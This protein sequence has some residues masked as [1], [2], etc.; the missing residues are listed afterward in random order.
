MPYNRTLWVNDQEPFINDVNLNKIEQGIFDA[1][2]LAE[3]NEAAIVALSQNAVN[4]VTV[5]TAD[6][7]ATQIDS[8]VAA[9]Y[10]S[11]DYF[12]TCSSDRGFFAT[13]FMVIHDDDTVNGAAYGAIG[14]LP[15]TFETELVNGNVVINLTPTQAI[16]EVKVV[17]TLISNSGVHEITQY[18]LPIDLQNETHPVIDLMVGGGEIDLHTDLQASTGLGTG[19]EYNPDPVI[20]F[21]GID[22]TPVDLNLLS[23]TYDINTATGGL[24]LQ[25]GINTLMGA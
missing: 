9:D 15:G 2:A 18:I 25:T 24:D 4:E 19:E 21:E 7:V 16:T 1:R 17:R 3:Q 10:R 20:W 11:A 23:G 8:F 14:T 6:T 5:N 13:R 12:I 22:T